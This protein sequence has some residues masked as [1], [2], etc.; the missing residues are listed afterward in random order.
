M[1]T[2]KIYAHREVPFSIA[3]YNAIRTGGALR[4]KE[5]Q[6]LV[7]VDHGLEQG[8][9]TAGNERERAK[10][11]RTEEYEGRCNDA[12]RFWQWVALGLAIVFVSFV[13]V[14]LSVF[15]IRMNDTFNS[16]QS[17]VSGQATEGSVQRIVAHVLQSA[18]NTETATLNMARATGLARDTAL[19]AAP[20]LQ[21]AMNETAGIVDDLRSFSFHPQWTVSTG[22]ISQS[23]RRRRD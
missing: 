2:G 23:G 8:N 21:H 22:G 14:M 18:Q 19:M 3:N 12:F 13:V 1:T 5:S 20:R 15:F 9:R 7:L 10:M 11:A 17:Q 16:V 4:G 6:S